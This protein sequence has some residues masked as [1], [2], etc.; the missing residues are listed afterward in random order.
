[1]A[2]GSVSLAAHSL[3]SQVQN[4]QA[5]KS[6]ETEMNVNTVSGGQ[7]FQE[8]TVNSFNKFAK[9]S[10]QQILDHISTHNATK[11]VTQRGMDIGSAVSFAI[12]SANSAVKK[13][14]QAINNAL[15]ENSE[16][17]FLEI[18]TASSDAQNTIRTLLEVRNKFMESFK[19]IMNMQM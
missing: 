17:S 1:M 8:M 16:A 13:Q 4:T 11:Q 19:E 12:G 14:E 6:I 7:N 18:A 15:E 9:M 5:N 10:S 2:I 3:Y